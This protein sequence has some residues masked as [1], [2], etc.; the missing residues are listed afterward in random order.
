[1]RVWRCKRVRLEPRQEGWEASLPAGRLD[2]HLRMVASDKRC[3]S[4]AMDG[5]RC[6]CELCGQG[7]TLTRLVARLCEPAHIPGLLT[8]LSVV[9][10]FSGDE[11]ASVGELFYDVLRC[12]CWLSLLALVCV[13]E[14]CLR[15]LCTLCVW[16]ATTEDKITWNWP[17]T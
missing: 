11:V 3:F 7:W 4:W 1:M 16:C 15:L 5:W 17:C 6:H 8:Q 14:I 12:V 9:D 10:G 2:W 13:V